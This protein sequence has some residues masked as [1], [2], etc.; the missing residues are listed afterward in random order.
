MWNLVR[1]KESGCKPS[2]ASTGQVI[3]SYPERMLGFGGGGGG[4]CCVVWSWS[5][6]YPARCLIGPVLAQSV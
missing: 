2:S 1:S 4:G 3:A 6:L 5:A